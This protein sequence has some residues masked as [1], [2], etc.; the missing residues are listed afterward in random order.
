MQLLGTSPW[1]HFLTQVFGMTS[2]QNFSV[3]A[4]DTR[5]LVPLLDTGPWYNFLV[6]LP[7]ACS[8]Q[9][10]HELCTMTTACPS[11]SNSTSL[12]CGPGNQGWFAANRTSTESAAVSGNAELSIHCLT[13]YTQ[14]SAVRCLMYSIVLVPDYW[15]ISCV[16][17]PVAVS[18]AHHHKHC[19]AMMS[20]H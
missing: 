7:E 11:C 12:Q 17:E 4:L 8:L 15:Q 5:S 10:Q 18:T 3:Q 14:Q 2:G 6:Q 20:M 19:C 16:G 13:S 9:S 1:Y